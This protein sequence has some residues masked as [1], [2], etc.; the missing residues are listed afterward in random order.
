MVNK[1][2]WRVD[3]KE[4]KIIKKA[5]YSGLK[6]K[7]ISIFEK[8]LSQKFYNKYSISVNSGTSA[9]HAALYAAGVQ[10]GDEVIVPPLTFSATAFSVLYLGAKPIFADVDKKTFNISPDEILK[11]IN[12]K[13]KAIITV[14]NF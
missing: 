3:N 4:L 6:G 5:I 1:N 13:T 2:F 14:C 9:L 12:K 7:F 10:K 8:K 11:K